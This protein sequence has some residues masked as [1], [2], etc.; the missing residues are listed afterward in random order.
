ML[1]KKKAYKNVERKHEV[2]QNLEWDIIDWDHDQAVEENL[3]KQNA[4]QL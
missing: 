4:I 3:F 1:L 2:L